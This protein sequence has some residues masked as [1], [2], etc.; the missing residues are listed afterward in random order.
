MS[1]L[2]KTFMHL[3]HQIRKIT[4]HTPKCVPNDDLKHGPRHMICFYAKRIP[5]AHIIKLK[6]KKETHSMNT[7]GLS[8]NPIKVSKLRV[9]Q[10]SKFVVDMTNFWYQSSYMLGHDSIRG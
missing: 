9:N 2:E 10:V 6:L 4:T 3:A 5:T 8:P 7:C 1:L